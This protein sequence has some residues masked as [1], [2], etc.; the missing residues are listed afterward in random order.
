MHEDEKN[1][2]STPEGAKPFKG[3][4]KKQYCAFEKCFGHASAFCLNGPFDSEA[5]MK[6]AKAQKLC[7][8][9]LR[10]ASHKLGDCRV[11]TKICIV[12]GEMHHRNLHEKSLVMNAIKRKKEESGRYS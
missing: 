6:I 1:P 4:F 2:R 12:C 3:K 8:L 5:K 11:K 7:L 9:C 10:Q